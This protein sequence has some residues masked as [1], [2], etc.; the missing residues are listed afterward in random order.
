MQEGAWSLYISFQNHNT[1]E[2]TGKVIYKPSVLDEKQLHSNRIDREA[3]KVQSSLGL[4]VSLLT[5]TKGSCVHVLL[6]TA[7]LSDTYEHLHKLCHLR[8]EETHAK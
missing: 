5:E 8:T 3:I 1:Q 7:C 6:I 2:G 4:Y